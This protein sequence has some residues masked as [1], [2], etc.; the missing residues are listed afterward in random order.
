M[1]LGVPWH[2][3]LGDA[4]IQKNGTASHPIVHL[5]LPFPMTK[6]NCQELRAETTCRKCRCLPVPSASCHVFFPSI[7]SFPHKVSDISQQPQ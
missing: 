4:I 1:T 2:R 5:F 3:L 7:E 6:A